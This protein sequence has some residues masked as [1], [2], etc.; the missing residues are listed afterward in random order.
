MDRAGGVLVA[1]CPAADRD[2]CDQPD[3]LEPLQRAVD[4]RDIDIRLLGQ[5]GGVDLLRGQV[6][7]AAL[8]HLQYDQSL[9]GQPVALAVERVSI[10]A[11]LHNLFPTTTER[12]RWDAPSFAAPANESAVSGGYHNTGSTY[13]RFSIPQAGTRESTRGHTT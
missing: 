12:A 10:V 1:Y 13:Q 9:R 6:L 7:A 8:D 2:R 3:I 11:G 5:H 4:R